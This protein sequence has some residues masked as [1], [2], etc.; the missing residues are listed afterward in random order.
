MGSRF[1]ID[2]HGALAAYLYAYYAEG[3]EPNIPMLLNYVNDAELNALITELSM[4]TISPTISNKVLEDCVHEILNYPKRLEIDK[5]E[6]ER[7]QAERQGNVVLAAQ[8][9]MEIVEMRNNLEKQ[10]KHG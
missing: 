6:E 9:A 1:N 8:I 3:H 4:I 7:R 5:K 2:E 10:L